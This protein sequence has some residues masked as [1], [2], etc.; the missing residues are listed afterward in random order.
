MILK[1]MVFF[2]LAGLAGQGWCAELESLRAQGLPDAGSIMA[3]IQQQPQLPQ[4]P[5]TTL[6]VCVFT[7]FR[8]NKCH[9]RCESGATLIE[10]AVRPDFSSGEPA[11]ACATHIFRPGPSPFAQFNKHIDSSDLRDL[12][13]DPNPEVRKAAVRASRPYIGNSYAQD[14]VR[15]ILGDQNE[16]TDIRVEAA[17]VLSYATGGSRVR[18]ELTDVIRY[19]NEPRELRVMAYKALWSATGHSR[20]QDLLMDA[21]RYSEKD[22]DARR[23]AI[24]ALFSASNNS[25]PQDVLSDVLRSRNE[26]EPTR[27]EALKSLYNAM[28]HY[29]VKDLMTDLVRD[30]NERKPVRL[31]AIKALSGANNDSRVKSLLEDIMERSSDTE[32][33]LAAIEALS[34][35]LADI[36]EYFHL[37]YKLENGGFVSPIEKE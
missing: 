37:P 13:R 1:A 3:Q 19:G 9:F 23:A 20:V 10:P 36:R 14:P 30:S 24:W 8:N 18:D 28:G 15:E 31:A 16:R 34:P 4:P 26:E 32:F 29:R 22:R 6:D 7:E 35:D 5:A 21:V 33:R 17:R 12:L 2:S 27:V 11:G 25:R